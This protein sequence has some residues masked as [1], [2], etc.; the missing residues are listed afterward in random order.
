MPL[1]IKIPLF[2]LV[3]ALADFSKVAEVQ[4]PPRIQPKPAD[5]KPQLPSQQG[6]I[7]TLSSG[8]PVPNAGMGCSS[9]NAALH[10]LGASPPSGTPLPL[11]PG[12][13]GD[14]M[15]AGFPVPTSSSVAA[16]AAAPVPTTAVAASASPAAVDGPLGHGHSVSHQRE[17]E[18]GQTSWDSQISDLQP[19]HEEYVKRTKWTRETESSR[20]G[21]TWFL[22]DESSLRKFEPRPLE[23]QKSGAVPS[24][25]P[26]GIPKASSVTS[27]SLA[28]I[29][30]GASPTD[31]PAVDFGSTGAAPFTAAGTD[32][33]WR[34]KGECRND[35]P[36]LLHPHPPVGPPPPPAAVG[37][38]DFVFDA[39]P[40]SP[41]TAAS[42]TMN[43]SPAALSADSSAQ[44]VPSITPEA[45]GAAD[46]I[47]PAPPPG[48]G[49]SPSSMKQGDNK[50]C[51]QQ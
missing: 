24:W 38:S 19:G 16:V 36:A 2:D 18:P 7:N 5:T 28:D 10:S 39:A 41:S 6:L 14:Q 26:S 35:L 48:L 25:H 42:G 44:V 45:S 23:V 29:F 43:Q 13:V 30:R 1:N 4:D 22:T 27:A 32:T 12:P 3:S 20:E 33:E 51:K 15:P 31:E 40:P 49:P 37:V 9:G 17:E 21:K 8:T 46:E 47:R 50:E 11:A 34:S